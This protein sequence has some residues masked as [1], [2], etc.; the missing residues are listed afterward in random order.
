MS[1]PLQAVI[2][3]G[4][5][6][7]R[8][9]SAVPD[10]PKVMAPVA[11]Q[12]FLHHLLTGIHRSGVRRAVLCLGYRAEEIAGHFGD[13]S[14]LGLRITYSVESKPLGTGGA[15]LNAAP[16]LDGSFL[17]LNGDT[18]LEVDLASLAAYHRARGG[19][20]TMVGRR[21]RGRP[22][23]DAGYVV[24]GRGGRALGILRGTVARVAGAREV[25]ACCGW[26]VCQREAL[27]RAP[28]TADGAFS[29]EAGIIAPLL[30][31]VYVFPTD[32]PFYDIGTPERYR[33]LKQEWER[34]DLS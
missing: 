24:A 10:L 34:H 12:P 29:L 22:R 26:Y 8:L 33:R 3:A 27:D 16:L 31:E 18:A 4:G 23:H 17:L 15:V 20:I 28:V 2:L 9:R 30:G 32:A 19:L 7:L 13:G 6:G 5:L 21:W 25:W 1:Q 11:G 14:R